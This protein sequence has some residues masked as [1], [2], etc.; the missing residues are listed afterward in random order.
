MKRNVWQRVDTTKSINVTCKIIRVLPDRLGRRA[1]A[2]AV[3]TE[4]QTSPL[5]YCKAVTLSCQRWPCPEPVLIN[6]SGFSEHRRKHPRQR[7]QRGRRSDEHVRSHRGIPRS[8]SLRFWNSS[9]VDCASCETDH[10]KHKHT[11]SKQKRAAACLGKS[12]SCPVLS[13]SWQIF[14]W[15]IEDEWSRRAVLKQITTLLNH[16][17]KRFYNKRF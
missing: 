12:W 16:I 4:K 15:I 17:D 8:R 6:W 2:A 11:R 14:N 1:E 9:H 3:P 5:V 10:S 13:L 7:K